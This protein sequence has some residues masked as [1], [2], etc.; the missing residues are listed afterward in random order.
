MPRNKWTSFRESILYRTFSV[1]SIIFLVVFAANAVA[2]SLVAH[3]LMPWDNML[4]AWGRVP[5][6]VSGNFF[7][8]IL[9]RN[10]HVVNAMF[11]TMLAV[12]RSWSLSIRRPCAKIYHYGGFHSGCNTAAT[13]WYFFFAVLVI[14]D[15]HR[16]G[17]F[18]I[19]SL[20]IMVITLTLLVIMI[21]F[22]TPYLRTVW[23][24]GFEVVH[25]QGG[26]VILLL[27]WAQIFLAAKVLSDGTRQ[28]YHLVLLINPTL[29]IHAA[30]TALVLYP[31]LYVQKVAVTNICLSNHVIK[32]CFSDLKF[33]AG[34]AIRVAKTALNEYHAFAVIPEPNN[35]PGFSILVS[36][37]GDWTSDLIK[38]P[39]THLWI[40]KITAFGVVSV[41]KMFSPVVIIAT[42]SGIGPCLA[43]FTALPN[44]DFRIV[45]ST[46]TPEEHYGADILNTVHMADPNATIINTD[47]NGR[48]DINA[49]AEEKFRETNAEAIVIIARSKTT[50][51]LVRAMEKKGI[52]CFGPI[53]DS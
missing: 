39:K 22:A 8:G 16:S 21:A 23:H 1:Y 41:A 17:A 18:W 45:W 30:T 6:F 14:A 7:V 28:S 36:N 38:N 31:W 24:D 49:L 12:P 27:F 26:W 53:F 46:R 3:Y 10:E 33:E 47:V 19:A 52:P 5:I 43:M 40:R 2:L 50:R 48:P 35:A 25:R 29:W 4:F 9:V 51:T 44:H 20:V 13:L 32:V 15:D 34:T 11:R 37:A 42:G